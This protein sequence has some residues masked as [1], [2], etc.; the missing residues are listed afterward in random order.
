MLIRRQTLNQNYHACRPKSAA[1]GKHVRNCDPFEP[2]RVQKGGTKTLSNENVRLASI[3]QN[4][5]ASASSQHAVVADDLAK[6]GRLW[7]FAAASGNKGHRFQLRKDATDAYCP[8]ARD[9]SK[10]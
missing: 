8:L 3:W 5:F 10:A 4:A 6:V 1:T 7:A 9:S 2:P